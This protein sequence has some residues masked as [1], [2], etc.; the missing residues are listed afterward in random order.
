[1]GSR[2]VKKGLRCVKKGPRCTDVVKRQTSGKI[3]AAFGIW[4][5]RGNAKGGLGTPCKEF[6]PSWPHLF[7][8][9]LILSSVALF[10]RFWPPYKN[11][12]P[13]LTPPGVFSWRRPCDDLYTEW[14]NWSKM[15]SGKRVCKMRMHVCSKTFGIRISS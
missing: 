6:G 15:A 1:M 3:S 4:W 8:E 10:V 12:R 14:E 5:P 11:L 13:P 9:N 7:W 2:S